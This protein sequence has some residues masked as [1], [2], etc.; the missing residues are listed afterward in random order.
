MLSPTPCATA[1]L[2]RVAHG[3]AANSNKRW[4]KCKFC[5][6]VL[7]PRPILECTAERK[8]ALRRTPGW[9]TLEKS[10][11]GVLPPSPILRH[12]TTSGHSGLGQV[13]PP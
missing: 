11:A 12:A 7:P 2:P 5:R 13:T 3:R 10:L 9:F 6:G 8:D 1:P 4:W